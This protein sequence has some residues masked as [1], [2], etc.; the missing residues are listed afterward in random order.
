MERNVTWMKSKETED[1]IEAL[2]V[3]QVNAAVRRLADPSKMVY[4]LSGDIA[5]AKAAG[6]D[7]SK[8]E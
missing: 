8:A 4:V 7:F 6:K 1:A 5:K 2:T 3:D